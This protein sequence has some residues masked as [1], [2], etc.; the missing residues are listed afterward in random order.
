MNTPATHWVVGAAIGLLAGGC[1]TYSDRTQAARSAL[2]AGD[3]DETL[4]QFNKILKVNSAEKLPEKLKKNGELIILE[5]G[6]VLQAKGDYALS[7]RDFEFADKQLE[8]LDIARDGAGK[9]GKYVF[10]DS[11]PK[12]K[13]SPTEKLSLNA[14]N[15]C[16]YLVRRDL[17]GAAIEARR[18]TVMR[19]YFR[20][21]DPEHAHG[22]FGSYL[23]GFVFERQGDINRALRYYDE[24]LQE[25]GFATLRPVIPRLAKGGTFRS[26][27]LNRYLSGSLEQGPQVS[28]TSPPQPQPQPQP[29]LQQVWTAADDLYWAPPTGDGELLVVAKVGRVP[30]KVPMRIPIGA[31]IG[32]AGAFITGDTTVLEYGMFKFVNYPELA[33]SGDLFER[34][35]VTL[36]GEPMPTDLAT[37]IASEILAE[38][39]E[40]K[41]KIIGAAISRLIVRAAA[42]E[43]ARVAGNQQSGLVG[44]LAAAAV[45]G[46]LVAADKPDTRSW[47]T[48]PARVFIARQRV[49]PGKHSIRVTAQGEGGQE[50]RTYDI[51]MPAEGFVMLDVT[52]LR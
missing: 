13:T 26:E 39:E 20:D 28:S 30:L 12:Y 27:R 10:S 8:L 32:L 2:Q 5:R 17:G 49:R 42:A 19:N 41:P 35:A 18:F 11:A 1:A 4:E 48:L 6:T 7:A 43:A 44:F 24:A 14:M 34:A 47:T 23:A 33:D 51:D 46:S 37:D 50:T 29:E 31:A 9:L 40:I 25:G 52:T 16:N 36:D 22:A 45:E 15:M 3:Y 21:Y 38:Y